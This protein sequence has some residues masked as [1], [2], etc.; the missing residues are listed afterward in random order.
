MS[1][2]TTPLAAAWEAFCRAED[3]YRKLAR[4]CQ[5]SPTPEEAEALHW[6]RQTL[7]EARAEF[8]RIKDDPSTWKTTP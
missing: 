4:I 2:T 7:Q 8:H 1:T 5:G 6:A 3:D